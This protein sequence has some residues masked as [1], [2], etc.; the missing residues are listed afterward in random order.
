MTISYFMS[1]DQLYGALFVPLA[2]FLIHRGMVSLKYA[3]MSPTEYAR[4]MNCRVES[5]YTKYIS[6]LVR[7]C[8]TKFV[9]ITFYI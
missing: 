7:V 8:N 2:L 5:V 3:T 6:Q 4:F 1:P 9:I